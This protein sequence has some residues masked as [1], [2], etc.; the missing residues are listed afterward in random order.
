MTINATRKIISLT[1]P[2]CSFGNTNTCRVDVTVD[3]FSPTYPYL[4]YPIADGGIFSNDTIPNTAARWKIISA[5][6]PTRWEWFDGGGYTFDALGAAVGD[7]VAIYEVKNWNGTGSDARANI[8][9]SV[10]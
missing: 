1:G 10:T 3:G 5:D 2:N 9:V 4:V 6:D 7:Y 8:T